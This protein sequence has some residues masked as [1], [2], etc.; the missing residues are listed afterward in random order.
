MPAGGGFGRAAR[1]GVLAMT[2]KITATATAA[3]LGFAALAGCQHAS[4][5]EKVVP[6]S[7]PAYT[8]EQLF[9]DANGHTVYRFVDRGS[10]HYYVTGPRGAQM[11][12]PRAAAT[13]PAAV[14]EPS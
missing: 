12:E 13:G 9:T 7:N 8:V 5:P 3:V 11:V 2:N 1:K 14:L 6:G 10:Y 4:R